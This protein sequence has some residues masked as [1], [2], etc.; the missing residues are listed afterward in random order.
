MVGHTGD[1][2]AAVAAIEAV[3]GCLGEVARAGPQA[4][5]GAC[6]VTADH[7]NA[8]NMLE[9]DGSPNT[10]HSTNPVPL[11]VTLGGLRLRDRGDPRRRRPD[12]PRSA[13]DRAAARDDR[14]LP[15]LCRLEP[16]LG[17]AEGRRG[18]M[19]GRR[20]RKRPA[21]KRS[22]RLGLLGSIWRRKQIVAICTLV[23]P[24]AA[25]FFSLR[26]EPHLRGNGDFSGPR[27]VEGGAALAHGGDRPRVARTGRRGHGEEL[28]GVD[29]ASRRRSDHGLDGRRVGRVPTVE[30]T[31]TR[32]SRR[33]RR[34]RDDVHGAVRR[35]HEELGDAFTGRAELVQSAA[36]P[37]A[38]CPRDRFATR[39]SGRAR[40]ADH[41]ARGGG[42]ARA[43][44]S[45]R[46]TARELDG[47]LG[48]PLSGGSRRAARSRLT[49]ACATSRPQTPRPSRWR[50]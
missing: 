49:S 27:A 26:E 10:A 3:D 39:S 40:R 28:G 31:A 12:G 22:G 25:L 13:R 36:R 50:G 5:G 46:R 33:R 16:C 29:A 15:T 47:L 35:L 2:P 14:P 48:V 21:G 20:A 17:H 8:D 42:A 7:G 37:E 6:I 23:V 45:P 32:R 1:I 19:A 30:A 43:P 41:R 9:P 24:A 38:P 34:S 4:S 44:R 11:I 18:L